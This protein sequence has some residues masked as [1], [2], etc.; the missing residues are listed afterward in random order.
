MSDIVLHWYRLDLRLSDLPS[1]S[2]AARSSASVLPVYVL[3]DDAAGDWRPGG[4]ARW[5]LHHSLEALRQ[6]I[7]SAG[8]TLVLRRGDTQTQ[9]LALCRESGARRIHCTRRY[10]PWAQAEEKMLHDAFAAE[11]IDLKRYPGALLHEPGQVL[12][13]SGEP[14]RVF[15][16]FWRACMA[17][18]VAAPVTTTP[19]W[20]TP[21][22]SEKL[23][24]WSLRPSNPDWA[25]GWERLWQPGE[26]GARARLGQFLDGAVASYAEQ[27]DQPAVDGTSRLSPHLHHGELSP[28][29]VW[30]DCEALR[31]SHPG[32]AAPLG[33]FQAELGW[34]EFSYHLLHFFPSIPENA[35]KPQFD[36]F[37]WEADDR[38]LR[39]WQRGQTGYPIVD[40]G[41][42]ELWQTGYM[43]NRVRMVVASFLCKHLLQHW[44]E[45]ARWFWDTLLDADLASNSCSWQWVAGSGADAAPYFRIFNPVTQGEKFDPQGHYVRR[46]VPELAAL[47]DRFLHHPWDAPPEV[48]SAAGII[49]GDHYPTPIV[50]HRAARTAAL[51]A[52]D[53]IKIA[54]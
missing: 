8:G 41:M 32:L 52:Y 3:D 9:L 14:F 15:T 6:Q 33:K 20:A 27:R 4:A 44:R 25:A 26:T 48:L 24:D 46:Y 1:L 36:A 54:R 28:R 34:R 47:P 21:L 42:R 51:A 23:D 2:A 10:E 45:G 39:A 22:P 19:T 49:L 37:P 30:A 17:Q 40:A 50:E 18:Q 31:A 29:Q 43:H 35:F 11:G 13:R 38:A 7:A 16:P 5:W 53:R 12:T